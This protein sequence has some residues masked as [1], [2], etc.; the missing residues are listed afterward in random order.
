MDDNSILDLYFTRAESAIS[1]TAKKYGKYCLSI[2]ENIL[3][4]TSDAE[5]CVND[6]YFKA[7]EAIPPKRPPSL[8]LF[9]GKITRN[10]SLN[11]FKGK[12]TQKRGGEFSVALSELEDCLPALEN[13]EAEFDAKSAGAAISEFLNTLDQENRVMFVRRYWFGDSVKSVAVR[14]NA[15]EAKVKSNL[16]RTRSKMKIFLDSKGVV[17]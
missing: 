5:E 10:L 8:R 3:G 1:E 13:T 14:F 4:D 15:T 9:L 16:F 7:W 17:I 2:A 12:N 6:T 11:R